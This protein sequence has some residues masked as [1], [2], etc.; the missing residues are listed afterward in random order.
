M[1]KTVSST[2]LAVITVVTIILRVVVGPGVLGGM[3]T[4]LALILGIS[5]IATFIG[6]RRR[7]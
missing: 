5:A 4:L 3:F 7:K 2:L 6:E 1:K